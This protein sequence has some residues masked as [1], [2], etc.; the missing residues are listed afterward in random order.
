MSKQMDSYSL[1]ER[2]SEVDLAV[3][4]LWTS[5]T[6]GVA[7]SL[8]VLYPFFTS[9]ARST[10]FPLSVLFIFLSG[11]SY[12]ISAISNGKN[13]ARICFLVIF[14][15]GICYA[16]FDLSTYFSG[17]IFRDIVKVLQDLMQITA[18]AALFAPNSNRWFE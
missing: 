2:P 7:G 1:N 16:I 13:W 8:V 6:L 5:F 12:L 17:S 3:A 10:L 11:Y 18:L 15:I 4:I 14:L 9:N